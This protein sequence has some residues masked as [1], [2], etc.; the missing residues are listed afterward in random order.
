MRRPSVPLLVGAGVA[1][2]LLIANVALTFFNTR[3]LRE[4]AQ[5]VA[6]TYEVIAGLENVLSLA[7]DAETG[8]RGFLITGEPEYLEPYNAATTAIHEEVGELER[9]TAD[10]PRQQARFPEL[11]ERIAAKLKELDETI[12][13]R[14]S[15]GFE[16]A[17]Q[18]VSTGRGKQEMDALRATVG[19]MIQREQILLR[20]RSQRAGQTYQKAV[21]TGFLSGLAAL[22]A[23][24][25]FLVLSRRYLTARAQAATV[26]AEQAERLQTTLASIG[27]AVIAT[28]TE[29][30]VTTL[31]AVAESLTGWKRE[32]AV[33]RS[34]DDVFR[35]VNETTREPVENP[36]VRSLTEG[37]IV[38]LANHTVLIARDGTERPIDDSAAPIRYK[39][40]EIVGCVLVFRDVAERRRS[41]LELERTA[42]ELRAVAARL[43][44]ADRRKNEF[45]AMLAH[46]LR[47]PLAPIRNALQILRL[48]RGSEE[49]AQ[50]AFEMM[51]RQIGQLVRLVDDLLDVSRISRGKID[52]RRELVELAS[53]LHLAVET[54]RPAIEAAR[55]E[56]TL[57]LPPQPVYLHADLVRLAQAFGNLLNNAA[58]YSEPEGRITVTAEFQG[59][60]VVVAVKDTGVG[61]APDMLPKVFDLFTQG[62]RSLER[63]QGGLGIGLTLVQRLVEMHGGSVSAASDGPGRGSE[64]V[65]RL[66]RL[67]EDV[68]PSPEPAAAREPGASSARRILVVDDNRDAATSLAM[69][70]ELTG[71][72]IQTAYDGL[73]A[74]E[75]AEAFRPDLVLLD[76]GLPELNGYEV[77]RKIREQPWG[78]TIVLMALT[79]WGQE[80]DRRKSR[81]AGF[82]GHMV[83]PVEYATLL[84]VIES[85]QG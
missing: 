72:E 75:A 80:E 27:D 11:R 62:D 37:L 24:V 73:E 3:Q 83:K 15:G 31:N 74:L 79:G 52:L 77:A 17:R 20:E 59:S 78:Q 61:I 55:H 34:L 68:N 64:L 35:I 2:A 43:S 28:D 12:A 58:K 65:V 19:D 81:D 54:T 30:R 4:H 76:I 42:E 84:K 41:E 36:A 47:N 22:V 21:L 45:L 71:N 26:I 5:W 29:G 57:K 7:K 63:S 39:E 14:R 69:L 49:A 9:L 67:S 53:I 85:L 8:Q 1:V 40:G 48:T 50:R 82:N 56:L 33:G 46:E 25:G 38:G 32:D 13:L 18:A 6:H 60:D 51:E 16:A 70:L 23:V 66:P 10:N 44:E